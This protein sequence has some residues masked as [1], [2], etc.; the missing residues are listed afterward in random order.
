MHNSQCMKN[1]KSHSNT[2]WLIPLPSGRDGEGAFLLL[3]QTQSLHDSTVAVDVARLQI[4]EQRATLT[5]QTGQSTLGAVVLT[6]L[7]HVLRQVLDAIGEQC[8]LAL[9]AT[10]V[11]CATAKLGEDLSLLG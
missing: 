8:N 5:Y 11:S 6:V 2:L 1:K 3:T 10:G 9:C 4:V 7:L